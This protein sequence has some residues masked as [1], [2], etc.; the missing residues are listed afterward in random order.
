MLQLL[1]CDG[2]IL[3]PIMVVGLLL[4]L[5]ITT[6]MSGKS[7]IREAEICMLRMRRIFTWS[8]AFALF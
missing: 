1:L 5:R 7:N 2:P 4:A 3:L 6:T 8:I